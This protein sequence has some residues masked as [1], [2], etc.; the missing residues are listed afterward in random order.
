MGLGAQMDKPDEPGNLTFSDSSRSHLQQCWSPELP[1][2]SSYPVRGSS[3]TSALDASHSTMH[4]GF[5]PPH[6]NHG[7]FVSNL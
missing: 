1:A 3:Q 4:L 2:A 6:K 5:F 7:L